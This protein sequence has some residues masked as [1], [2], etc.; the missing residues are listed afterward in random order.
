MNLILDKRVSE[1]LFLQ[2]EFSDVKILREDKTISLSYNEVFKN[3]QAIPTSSCEIKIAAIS[4]NVIESL[5][6]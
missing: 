2:H 5:V 4:A 6:F 1:K 3:M